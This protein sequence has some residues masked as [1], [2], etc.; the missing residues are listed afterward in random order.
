[1]NDDP[2]GHASAMKPFPGFIAGPLAPYKLAFMLPLLSALICPAG[3]LSSFY[4]FGPPAIAFTWLY[5]RLRNKR[6]EV[7]RVEFLTYGSLR[8]E[9]NLT[10]PPWWRVMWR[11]NTLCVTPKYCSLKSENDYLVSSQH[12]DG[13]G[14]IKSPFTDGIIMCLCDWITIRKDFSAYIHSQV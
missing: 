13:P 14:S 3:F 7:L 1:M 5:C 12:K 9:P 11:E 8:P 10:I 4:G 6:K 2:D